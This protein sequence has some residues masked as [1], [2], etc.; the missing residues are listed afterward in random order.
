MPI[1]EFIGACL[2]FSAFLL[3]FSSFLIAAKYFFRWESDLTSGM[4]WVTAAVLAAL[5][6][7]LITQNWHGPAVGLALYLLLVFFYRHLIPVTSLFGVFFLISMV[8]PSLFGSLWVF[9]LAYSIYSNLQP[10]W[11]LSVLIFLVTA[12]Y[13]AFIVL[14]I[15]M[16]SCLGLVRFSDL[17]FR[18]PRR[19]AAWKKSL[20]PRTDFPLVSIH[21]PCYAEPPDIV[22]ETLNALAALDYPNFEVIVLDNNTRETSLWKPLEGY[23][24]KLGDRFRFYHFAPLPGAKAG[25]LNKALELTSQ[26]AKLVAVVDAD[27]KAEP[28]FLKKLV[29]YF[30]DPKTGFVQ[31]CHDYRNWEQSHYLTACYYE[32]AMHFKLDLPGQSEWDTAYTVGTMCLIRKKALE[33]AGGWAKWCLTEDSEVAVRLH[34]L[35]YAGYF[36]K[37]TFGR[38]LI[39]ETFDEYKKQRFRWT[40]GSIQQFQKHWRL[41][42]PWNKESG[43]ALKQ[44]V[45]EIF[46]SLSISFTESFF[47]MATLPLTLA[48]I[49]LTVF[50]EH[51][52]EVPTSVWAL[53]GALMIRNVICNLIRNKLIGGN[54]LSYLYTGIA[55]RSL[56]F[57][58]SMSFYKAWFSQNLNWNRTNK[59]KQSHNFVRGFFSSRSEIF[60]GLVYLCGIVFLFPYITFQ[61]PNLILLVTLGLLNQMISYFCAPL[62]AF[63]SEKELSNERKQMLSPIS[64]NL[65]SKTETTTTESTENTRGV[66]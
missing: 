50:K 49:W 28:D 46:H 51:N 57:T 63:V 42:L 8:I 60:M 53:I 59:F 40:S 35:G 3:L 62:M 13:T 45:S 34:N 10:E 6:A 2:Y 33:E 17:Y 19:N 39:P 16:Y 36:L 66:L 55:V 32:Y 37:D 52:W 12:F 23:C 54:L 24:Q 48:T 7:F 20:H 29:G 61:S 5:I 11:L 1:A 64:A 14:N 38:G 65:R 15:M 25:A 43:L 4:T 56:S 21:V 30:D 47:L 41:Y 26:E 22:I 31:T 58:R 44:K 18:F 9:Q 27:Y